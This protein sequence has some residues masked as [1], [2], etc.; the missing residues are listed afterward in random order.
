MATILLGILA[1]TLVV[2]GGISRDRYWIVAE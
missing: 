1:R 2:Y